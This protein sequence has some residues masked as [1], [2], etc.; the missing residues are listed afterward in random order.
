MMEKYFYKAR[1]INGNVSEG[2]FEGEEEE[3]LKFLDSQGLVPVHL[4]KS[5]P[6]LNIKHIERKLTSITKKELI[7]FTSQLATML[8]AGLSITRS[9]RAISVQTRNKRFRKALED[10]ENSL[11]KGRTFYNSLSLYPE[12]FD[13]IYIATVQIGEISGN[14]PSILFKIAENLE[15]EE[16]LRLKIKNA[17]LYP[18][19]VITAIFIAVI[20]LIVFVIPRF[21]AL[22]KG[23]K[24]D[25]PLPTKILI[26]ISGFF[27]KYWM[28]IALAFM[29]VI[30]VYMYLKNTRSGKQIYDPFLLKIPIIGD[31]VIK[32]IMTRFSRFFS[33][34]FS[35]GVVITQILD[36]LGKVMDNV[37]FEK[38]LKEIKNHI[39]NGMGFGEAVAQTGIFTPLTL[40]MINVGEETGALDE[41][42]KRVSEFYESELDYTIKNLTTLIEPILLVFIFGMVLFLALSVF[43]PMWDMVKFVGK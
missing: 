26:G 14:L 37:V 3:V 2:F 29:G 6:L 42:L 38:K 40:E 41:M 4:S 36:L 15:K 32:I 19:I 24:V 1:D 28:F 27:S 33:M 23:F 39:L 20:V 10:I 17:T 5:A 25:L 43:L 35:S 18:K 13:N 12:Y 8:R 22:Y 16:E 11:E 9:L 7:L 34:L 30:L 31:I 21:A